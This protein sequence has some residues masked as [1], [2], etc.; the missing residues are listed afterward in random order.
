MLIK[1]KT[2]Q[3]KINIKPSPAAIHSKVFLEIYNKQKEIKNENKSIQHCIKPVRITYLKPNIILASRHKI[4]TGRKHRLRPYKLAHLAGGALL[5]EF[6]EHISKIWVHKVLKRE[7]VKNETLFNL[8]PGPNIAT[9]HT[10]KLMTIA[11]CPFKK[12]LTA[13]AVIT[14]SSAINKPI[15]KEIHKKYQF[16]K[17]LEFINKPRALKKIMRAAFI[18]RKNINKIFKLKKFKRVLDKNIIRYQRK[19]RFRRFIARCMFKMFKKKKWK[20]PYFAQ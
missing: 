7:F 10:L 16:N 14:N 15:V 8:I 17:Q 13:Y 9:N 20:A 5:K 3:K 1:N 6:Q 4:K 18:Y 12:K 2:K 11:E 19:T